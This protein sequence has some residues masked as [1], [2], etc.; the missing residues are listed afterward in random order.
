MVEDGGLL[1][2]RSLVLELVGGKLPD[3]APA[4]RTTAGM[5]KFD[6]VP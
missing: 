1:Q 5:P 4:P 2:G 6:A 3:A